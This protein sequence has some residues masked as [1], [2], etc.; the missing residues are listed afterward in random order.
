MRLK[1]LHKYASLLLALGVIAGMSEQVFAAFDNLIPQ[2][3]RGKFFTPS[4]RLRASYNDNVSAQR[5]RSA[6][7]L[8]GDQIIKSPVFYTEPRVSIRLPFSQTFIGIDYKY[9]FAYFSARPNDNEDNAH[10]LD[11]RL[12]H[13]FSQRLSLDVQHAFTYQQQ[14]VIKRHSTVIRSDGTYTRNEFETAVK[15]DVTKFFYLTGRYMLNDLDFKTSAGSSTFDATENRIGLE[16]A[17]VLNKNT[18]LLSG[19]TFADKSYDKRANADYDSHIIFGGINYRFG[20]YFTVD[21]T[22]G[23]DFRFHESPTRTT[24]LDIGLVPLYPGP[25]IPAGSAIGPIKV[26]QTDVGHNPFVT[27]R[28][29]TN[30]F[31]NAVITLGYSLLTT[32]TEQTSFT[33]A[34]VE[35]YSLQVSYRILPKVTVDL[36]FLYI[37]E[38]Y[39]GTLFTTTEDGGLLVKLPLLDHP[40][41]KVFRMGAVVSYQVTPWLFYEL[42]YRRTDSDSD[43]TGSTYQ[44]NEYFTGVNAIF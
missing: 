26:G 34:D 28:L 12:K 10:D 6:T 5:G 25:G 11:L 38:N 30:Y 31:R 9:S 13:N 43:F 8:A 15:Y 24:G 36:S 17:Y 18:V 29:T 39:L 33:D 20:K 37:D 21:A 22:G 1:S 7:G 40:S 35:S 32:T 42:G 19:Y 27:A 16:S 4:I 44:R 2:R 23:V 41:T 3:Q 14:G